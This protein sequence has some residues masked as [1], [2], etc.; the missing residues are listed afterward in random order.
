MFTVNVCWIGHQLTGTSCGRE[1]PKLRLQ[2][3]WP[4]SSHGHTAQAIQATC[5]CRV[6]TSNK[7]CGAFK[8]LENGDTKFLQYSIQYTDPACSQR[9]SAT[10]ALTTCLGRRLQPKFQLDLDLEM[11]LGEQEVTYL[12]SC[13]AQHTVQFSSV[14][15]ITRNGTFHATHALHIE[16]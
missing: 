1:Q 16:F 11:T 5:R 4:T 14:A 13:I 6:Y 15:F 8:S 12:L 9:N 2:N 10:Q 7:A 3:S